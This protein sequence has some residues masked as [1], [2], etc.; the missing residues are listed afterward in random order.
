M[1]KENLNK[2]K[3][4]KGLFFK[5]MKATISGFYGK[6]NHVGIENI[7]NEPCI[8][9]GNHAQINGP[10]IAEMRSPFPHYTWC[11]GDMLHLKE[12]P[13]YAFQDFWRYKP[14]W[15]HW[16]YKM[17]SYILAPLGTYIFK[18]ADV[19][20][21][22]NDMRTVSTF[23]NSTKILKEGNHLIVFPE[24]HEAF[25]HII[26]EFKDKFVDLARLFH[27]E[28]GKEL[29][30]VPMY[31]APKLKTVIYG[32]PIKFNNNINIGEERKKVCDYLK[33]E[34]TILAQSLPA[35]TVIPYANIPKK[36]YPKSK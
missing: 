26:N 33:S 4:K 20:G 3:K 9:V 10:I 19:I 13:S 2:T 35:H 7:P 8:I 16:F 12:F 24:K 14:K 25:N 31:I 30:F 17:L 34:I 29:S 6:V 11:I 15:T 32:K 27:K 28:T 21:V 23:K 22:Y 1:T 18:N 36:L 5:L